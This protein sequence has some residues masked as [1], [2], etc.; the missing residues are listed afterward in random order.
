MGTPPV[1]DPG[2]VLPATRSR[3]NITTMLSSTSALRSAAARLLLRHRSRA[4]TRLLSSSAPAVR[5]PADVI[6]DDGE[7]GLV[8]HY[9]ANGAS[10]SVRQITLA[11]APADRPEVELPPQQLADLDR[12][13]E[14]LL[15]PLPRIPTQRE[16]IEKR[17]AVIEASDTLAF[18]ALPEQDIGDAESWAHRLR[19]LSAQ[20]L[21]DVA[22]DAFEEMEQRGLADLGP[23]PDGACFH[24]LADA[25]ARAGDVDG[26]EYVIARAQSH[27]LPLNAPYFTSLVGAHRRAA[28][29][30]AGHVCMAILERCRAIGVKEDTPLHT[31]MI[32]WHVA[33]GATEEAWVAYH[34]AR[35]VDCAPDAVTYTAMFVAC[36][37][38]DDWTGLNCG[39]WTVDVTGADLRARLWRECGRGWS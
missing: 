25:Y 12:L 17:R 10:R 8:G 37:Q 29:P 28:T 18:F 26:V 5:P 2:V 3:Y 36:A 33:Q 14:T 22:R 1:H 34:H 23:R 38:V 15:E 20:D 9:A 30:H 31:A 32:C 19:C 39:L 11:L 4:A 21:P 13:Y 27:I 16:R 35:N 6:D 7:D 24:A